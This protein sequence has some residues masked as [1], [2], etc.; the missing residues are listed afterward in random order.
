MRF[1]NGDYNIELEA[2]PLTADH[3][4][5][6]PGK[7]GTIAMV[8]DIPPAGG[9]AIAVDTYAAARALTS[10][11]LAGQSTV[12]VRGRNAAN[13]GAGGLFSVVSG[14][15]ADDDG[16][17]LLAA[18]NTI[19]LVRIYDGMASAAW[20]GV[21]PSSNDVGPA[22]Q[23][24]QDW[25][26]SF[27]QKRGIFIPEGLYYIRTPVTLKVP[28]EG[29]RPEGTSDGNHGTVFQWVSPS[30]WPSTVNGKLCDLFEPVFEAA[31]NNSTTISNISLY[32]DYEGNGSNRDTYLDGDKFPSLKFFKI[33]NRGMTGIEIA[34]GV[35]LI[36]CKIQSFLLGAQ[37][38]DASHTRIHN[39][40]VDAN[41]IGVFYWSNRGDHQITDTGLGGNHLA[42][43]SA[44]GE[45]WT[46]Q[47]DGN[48]MGFGPYGLLQIATPKND[49]L[50][51]TRARWRHWWANSYAVKKA[52]RFNVSTLSGVYGEYQLGDTV[53]LFN[54]DTPSQNGIWIVN[55]GAWTRD[56]AFTPVE[57]AVVA[58]K[59][60][61]NQN[62]AETVWQ[63]T[64]ANPV[65]GQP[66]TFTDNPAGALWECL[67]RN[68][69]FESCG[70]A[71]IRVLKSAACGN[72]EF[73]FAG[74]GF[75]GQ[76]APN[77]LTLSTSLL[78]AMGEQQQQ[79]LFWFGSIVSGFVFREDNFTNAGLTPN[80]GSVRA[81]NYIHEFNPPTN[82]DID[83]R[84]LGKIT[85]GRIVTQRSPG[86]V[87]HRSRLSG[88]NNASVNR[89]QDMPLLY[90]PGK[91]QPGSL[92]DL[93]NPL[94][95]TAGGS[96]LLSLVDAAGVDSYPIDM[97]TTVPVNA[98]AIY[99]NKNT[100]PWAWG[101]R[102]T[103]TFP[104][105]GQRYGHFWAWV[106]GKMSIKIRPRNGSGEIVSYQA[107]TRSEISGWQPLQLG[108]MD[109]SGA[110]HIEFRVDS[111]N[112]SSFWMAGCVF[113]W[114]DYAPYSE[115]LKPA[116]RD[117]L[118]FLSGNFS[119]TIDTAAL[120]ADRAIT[121]PDKSGT[122][123]VS[124][125]VG[126]T[127]A[128]SLAAT[129]QAAGR[130]AIGLGSIAT[131]NSNSVAITGGT[132]SDARFSGLIAASF[133]EGVSGSVD[134]SAF[135]DRLADADRRMDV[136]YTWTGTAG[137]TAALWDPSPETACVIQPNGQLIVEVDFG[138]VAPWTANAA[139]GF[140]YGLGNFHTIVFNTDIPA[141]VSW[142]LY[143]PISGVDAWGPPVTQ[144][145]LAGYSV[146]RI[147]APN[148][149]SAKKIRITITAGA[150]ICRISGLRYIPSRADSNDQATVLLN[151]GGAS[152]RCHTPITVQ[153]KGGVNQTVIGAGTIRLKAGATVS[154]ILTATKAAA[155][156][157]PETIAVTGA[158]V[159]DIAW[160]SEAV[161]AKVTAA[162]TVSFNG[163]GL[164]GTIRA[165]VMRAT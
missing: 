47:F 33:P 56:P 139:G 111:E 99:F 122:L 17:V 116:T 165:I 164:T 162:N 81:G 108:N 29:V 40:T 101:Y 2:A 31:P 62:I 119:N 134:R 120:T 124:S 112:N 48:H 149:T 73:A 41:Y 163:T 68:T 18:S 158:A 144:S 151:S 50:R 54:Q 160:I 77:T 146:N 59:P 52:S 20:W 70:A 159:G 104:A 103:A 153:D 91:L 75:E 90:N 61:G 87:A 69:R 19:R 44:G 67:F 140:S 13:D 161:P 137:S 32:G 36:N 114:D 115:T 86:G 78:A 43:T 128:A 156:T 113:S 106:K 1:R 30:T 85:F 71:A 4:A 45:G 58:V 25:A 155:G 94:A 105:M 96:T 152:Q 89:Y 127:G 84:G 12:F 76:P 42:G 143:Y 39:C 92:F 147:A 66:I 64:S 142:E 23:A 22:L 9:S 15:G 118:Q 157:N 11:Q 51:D 16:A 102:Q 10:G 7:S 135:V 28:T 6:L 8:S 49:S 121:A 27:S 65:I 72:C 130:T 110:T 14:V 5:T 55:S 63:V 125:D 3:V 131:Q 109:F 126:A 136:T 107:D 145:G 83:L 34:R 148:I 93:L 141:S 132:I 95:W 37:I 74:A 117:G 53:G 123:I 79:Y 100:N 88:D 97:A 82:A 57:G 35:E 38:R 133:F 46:V 98:K 80:S 24:A 129:T 60:S 150:S 26:D 138:A 154:Q 21:L